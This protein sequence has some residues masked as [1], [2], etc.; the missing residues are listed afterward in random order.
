MLRELAL[1]AGYGGFALGFRA[2]G[3]PVRTVCNVERDSYAAAVLVARMEEATLDRA[4]VW[5]DLATFDGAAWRGAVDLITAGFPCQP[6]S[7]A[8]QRRGVDDERWL[9]PA[10]ARIVRD[11]GPRLVFL[12]NVPGLNRASD[13]GGLSFVLQDLADLGFDAEWGLLS[14]SAVG[15]SH[16]RER[17][18]LV[19]HSRL[20]RLEGV[21]R[22]PGHRV[23]RAWHDVDGPGGADVADATG[24]R[25]DQRR[26]QAI[27]SPAVRWDGPARGFPPLPDDIDGWR[28][29]IAA[30]GPEPSVRRSTD[31]RPLGLADALHLGGNGLVPLAA[32]HAFRQLAGRLGT[33]G[34]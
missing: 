8:G 2:I 6:W 20:D 13:G 25:R 26:R 22:E 16:K 32:G 12:E 30:G 7:S 27:E 4:P 24:A 1:C 29:W 14:A 18:W 10:I 15:A 17:F 3:L 33:V 5:D 9:W 19:A 11:V 21:G 34:E 23:D 28:E 31:G